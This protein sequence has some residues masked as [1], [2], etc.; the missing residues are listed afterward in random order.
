MNDA[1]FWNGVERIETDYF[2]DM[3]TARFRRR[4]RGKGFDKA[5]IDERQEAID[6][7]R[8][9]INGAVTDG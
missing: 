8:K 1:R 4:M 2:A 7:D 3:D 9:A 5:V 6:G